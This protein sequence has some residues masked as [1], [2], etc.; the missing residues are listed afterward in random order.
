MGKG[1]W[2]DYQSAPV[3]EH[4]PWE[5][6]RPPGFEQLQQTVSG[7]PQQDQPDKQGFLSALGQ[8]VLGA[9]ASMLG[10]P[11][12]TVYQS[13]KRLIGEYRSL[14]ETGKSLAANQ[15][16]QRI[17]S[18]YGP[19]YSLVSAPA[20]EAIGVNVPAI[21]QAAS[22]GDTAGIAG[23]L[24]V[25]TAMAISPMISKGIGLAKG[26][27]KIALARPE[28]VLAEQ[29]VKH[30]S[31]A[32]ATPA[33]K[34]GSKAAAMDVDLRA[35]TP[36]L[37]AIAR[38]VPK[39]K[40]AEGLHQVAEHIE[41]KQLEMW[42]QG[43]EPGIAR[44]PNLIVDTP[45]LVDA[46]KSAVSKMAAR[47]NPPEAK[48]ALTW[49]NDSV[50]PDMNISELDQFIRETNA[51]LKG[52][53]SLAAYGPIGIRVRQ[54]VVKASRNEVD[55]LLE[56]AGESGIKELNRRWGALENIK[57]RIQERAVQEA[58]KEAKKGIVP[59]WVHLYSFVHPTAAAI[60]V[61][62]G[63]GIRISR[64]FN[65]TQMGRFIKGFELLGKANLEPV[66]YPSAP[67]SP[68]IAGL[69][70]AGAIPMPSA[71]DASYVRG[72]PGMQEAPSA[73][74]FGRLL[75]QGEGI[76]PLTTPP[77][78]YS[79]AGSH[80]TGPRSIPI[81]MQ[82]QPT[83]PWLGSPEFNSLPPQIQ[84]AL[85]MRYQRMLNPAGSI[86]VGPSTL[87]QSLAKRTLATKRRK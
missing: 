53:D 84:E 16:E 12:G 63:A 42:K 65:P 5:D 26:S 43:H 75:P 51:D 36:D 52:K 32:L 87:P 60:P 47:V 56:S 38:Q 35:V 55:A 82:P 9:G 70:G 11:P 37:S 3:V 2:E 6:Y 34:G 31:D 45:K 14:K 41:A 21:E 69:L 25:P 39:I 54:A 71:P 29:G 80:P 66:P 18:G 40:G 61:S 78:A 48:A 85:Y 28:M 10:G 7:Y 24:V 19:G 50:L 8:D 57:T 30:L 67:V 20:A 73:I 59:E 49:L 74:R 44:N 72:V 83:A 68:R 81:E 15:Y 64:I 17:K 33:G 62:V 86:Q 13:G 23:H 4:G 27:N 46:G 77:P 79:A 22:V 76:G 58:G 1:P